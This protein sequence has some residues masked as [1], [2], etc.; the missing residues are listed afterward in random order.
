M[1][2]LDDVTM[3]PASITDIPTSSAFLFLLHVGGAETVQPEVIP[4]PSGVK[5][6]GRHADADITLLDPRASREHGELTVST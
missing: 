6:L 2:L 4:L 5:T 1:G 3:D